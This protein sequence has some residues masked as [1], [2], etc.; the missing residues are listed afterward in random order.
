MNVRIGQCDVLSEVPSYT[1]IFEYSIVLSF[2]EGSDL[3]PS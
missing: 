2:S 3:L 1:I